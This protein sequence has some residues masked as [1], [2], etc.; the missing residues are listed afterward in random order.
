MFIPF[1]FLILLPE[2]FRNLRFVHISIPPKEPKLFDETFIIYSEGSMIAA[3]LISLL[4]DK[5]T[6]LSYF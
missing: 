5:L 2:M 1:M 4:L 6:L 3:I